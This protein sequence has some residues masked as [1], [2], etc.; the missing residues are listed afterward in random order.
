VISTNLRVKVDEEDVI[1]KINCEDAKLSNV[2][3][4]MINAM[5]NLVKEYRKR[6]FNS[7]LTTTIIKLR[8]LVFAKSCI[9]T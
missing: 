8:N 9:I 3:F 2:S 4:I 6:R 1:I 5:S 7:S